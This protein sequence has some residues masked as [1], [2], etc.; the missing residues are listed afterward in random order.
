VFG[1][2]L[3]GGGVELVGVPH[4]WQNFPITFVWPQLEQTDPTEGGGEE[5]TCGVPQEGQNLEPGGRD[6]LHEEQEKFPD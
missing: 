6:V 4:E 5:S 1:L 3:E 2:F